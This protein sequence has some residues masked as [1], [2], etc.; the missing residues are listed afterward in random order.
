MPVKKNARHRKYA[1][2]RVKDAGSSLLKFS[3][4]S[5][6]LHAVGRGPISMY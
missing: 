1:P 4:I 5:L 2:M 3:T 6:G